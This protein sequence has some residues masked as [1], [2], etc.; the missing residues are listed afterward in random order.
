MLRRPASP[1]SLSASSSPPRSKS[2]R[3]AGRGDLDRF[4]KLPWRIYAEDPQWVPPLLLDVKE[5]LNRRKHPF[6]QHGDATQF[7]AI[8][9]DETVGRI[10][11]SDDPLCNQQHGE[12]VGCFGMFECVDDRADGPRL[13]GCGRRLA[14]RPRPDRDPRPDR[15]FAQLSLRPADR[16]VRHAAA[17]HDE[18]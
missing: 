17:D 2:A 7:I 6:Y 12:N 3:S 15:L 13:A 11:V 5:F 8:R 18:P 9:G 1:L 16:R 10:L 4:L 14:P